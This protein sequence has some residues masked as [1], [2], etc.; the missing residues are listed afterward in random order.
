[1][2][3]PAGKHHEDAG[4]VFA[5]VLVMLAS[6]R[7]SGG[8]PRLLPADHPDDQDDEQDE[9]DR[10]DADIHSRSLCLLEEGIVC[11]ALSGSG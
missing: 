2:F 6:V 10:S 7:L 3:P 9:H 8:R 5:G 4:N 1:M 11:T